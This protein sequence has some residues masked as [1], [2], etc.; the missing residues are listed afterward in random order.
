MEAIL[1]HVIIWV[2]FTYYLVSYLGNSD[3]KNSYNDFFKIYD[4]TDF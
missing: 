4:F 3:L 1:S 2:R